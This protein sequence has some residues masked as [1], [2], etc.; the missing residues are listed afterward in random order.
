MHLFPMHNMQVEADKYICEFNLRM[1][2]LT[3]WDMMCS[4]VDGIRHC[5][6]TGIGKHHPNVCVFA[7]DVGKTY[8]FAPCFLKDVVKDVWKTLYFLARR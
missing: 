4:R 7:K 5:D 8:P 6:I 1:D 3:L 2:P